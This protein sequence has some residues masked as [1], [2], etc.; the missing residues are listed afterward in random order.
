MPGRSRLT[1]EILVR[2]NPRLLRRRPRR[3]V[4]SRADLRRVVVLHPVDKQRD[5]VLGPLGAAQVGRGPPGP[6]RGDFERP[7]VG[8]HGCVDVD[9]VRVE[10]V[11][12]VGVL[13]GPG[14]ECLQLRLGLRHVGVEVVEV[15]QLLRLCSGV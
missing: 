13:S 10:V 7:P 3:R 1:V 5:G 6:R 8:D 14:F 2:V 12:D 15:A 11:G 9:V 4:D